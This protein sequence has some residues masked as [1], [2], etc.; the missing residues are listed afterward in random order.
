MVKAVPPKIYWDSNCFI[1]FIGNEPDRMEVCAA[2]LHQA[3]TGQIE[4][5][6]SCMAIVETVRI[7]NVGDSESNDRI[8]AFFNRAFIVK[9]DVN[10]PIAHQARRLQLVTNL[11][12]RDAVHLATAL[13][14]GADVL[15]TYDSDLLRL[16]CEALGLE[17][18]VEE[19]S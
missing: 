2:I 17:I 13:F 8:Q 7:R 19:P 11:R 4:L 9:M 6:T 15:Q 16:D 3:E 18:R 5:Y 1:A 12:A 10:I 14:V